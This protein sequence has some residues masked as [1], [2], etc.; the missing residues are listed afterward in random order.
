VSGTWPL[1]HGKY[2]S[3]LPLHDPEGFFPELRMAAESPQEEDFRRAIRDLL[4]EEL[5]EL[6]GKW[7]NIGVQ[8]P[9]SY[10]PSLAVKAAESGA[11]MVGLHH[12]T[13]F[14]TEARV[15]PEALGLP[16]RPAGFD[17]LCKLV[18]AGDLSDPKAVLHACEAFWKGAQDWCRKHGESIT[19][20]KRIPF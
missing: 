3:V 15:L 9:V 8:G 11:M 12:R 18:M 7:R 14:T 4:V 2:F 19:E 5:F 16:N 20:S 13:C 1:T 17:Q 6:A 10:L